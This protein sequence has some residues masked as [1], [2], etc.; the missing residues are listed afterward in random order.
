MGI[1]YR[2]YQI[3]PEGESPL[4]A[5]ITPEALASRKVVCRETFTE[6]SETANL[7]FNEQE[8]DT[9]AI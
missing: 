5:G 8:L 9:E 4:C 6:G 1:R 2:R 7:G 3:I